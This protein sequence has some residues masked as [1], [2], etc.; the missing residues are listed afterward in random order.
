V[1]RFAV[2][3]IGYDADYAGAGEAHGVLRGGGEVE[4]VG[5]RVEEGLRWG[6]DSLWEG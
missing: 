4:V 1:R 3:A 2:G 6:P 5:C